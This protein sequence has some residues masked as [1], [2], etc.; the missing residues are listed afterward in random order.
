MI[1][2]YCNKSLPKKCHQ[3]M[4][5]Q[6]CLFEITDKIAQLNELKEMNNELIIVISQEEYERE[7]TR[8]TNYGRLI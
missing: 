6:E 3:F 2:K 1:C 8:L 4:L 5:H 7:F